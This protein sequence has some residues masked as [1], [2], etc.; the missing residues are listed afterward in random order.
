MSLAVGSGGTAANSTLYYPQMG[1]P[2]RVGRVRGAGHHR[3][4][5]VEV[6]RSGG[7]VSDGA[8]SY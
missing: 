4:G 5:K 2:S 1:G 7:E 6:V 8:L 3:H